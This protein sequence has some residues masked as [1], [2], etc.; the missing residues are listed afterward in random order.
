LCLI[1]ATGMLIVW[2]IRFLHVKNELSDVNISS[3]RNEVD[4]HRESDNSDE[5]VPELHTHRRAEVNSKT[6]RIPVI[7]M[8]L[9][10]TSAGIADITEA[11]MMFRFA[12]FKTLLPSF[13]KTISEHYKYDF[14]LA[15]DSTDT[16][17][18]DRQFISS[19]TQNFRK[20]IDESCAA[21]SSAIN[22]HF[23]ECSH[24]GSPARAQNDAMME[25]YLDGCDYFYRI[26]DDIYFLSP[27][28]TEEFITTLQGFTPPF[29]GV[30]GPMH[31]GGN[32][33]IL[34][35]DFVHR[36]HINIFGFY[37]PRLFTDW[38]ADDWMT[39]V[40]QPEWSIKVASVKVRHT[41]ETGTRYEVD[42]NRG[43]LWERR[44]EQ[45]RASLLRYTLLR[46][47]NEYVENVLCASL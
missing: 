18:G 39:S 17:F 24:T 38:W 43:Q 28:W 37:Y 2:T 33:K 44:V 45:D 26:N 5:D 29:V 14:Y 9:A 35:F 19:Y 7:A 4:I 25:A 47:S 8:G 21:L 3:V 6:V 13:C 27:G 34:T 41:M 22:L 31:S 11:N 1:F 30:V 12:F 23:I 32:E 20:R 46:L 10:V 36:T 42:I 40:Y 15:F 16:F